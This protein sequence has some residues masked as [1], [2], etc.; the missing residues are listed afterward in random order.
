MIS[1]KV[2]ISGRPPDRPLRAAPNFRRHAAHEAALALE[3]SGEKVEYVEAR[4][5]GDWHARRLAIEI[6]GGFHGHRP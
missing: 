3:G 5:E 1:S 6:T 4:L 2:F